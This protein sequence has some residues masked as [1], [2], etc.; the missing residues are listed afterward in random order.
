MREI[1]AIF[2][3]LSVMG[4]I[5]Y[6]LARRLHQGLFCFFPKWRFWPV[7]TAIYTTLILLVA[8]FI[9]GLT[10][11]PKE[12]KHILSLISSYCMGVMLYLLLF[13]VTA[14]LLLFVPKRM[15]LSFT[16]HRLFKGLVTV[17]V[18][19]LTTSTCV[20][21][22]INAQT[23][24][25]VS[26]DIPLSGKQDVSDMNIVLVS[27][28]HLGSIGSESRLNK[29]VDEIN[30][31]NP[32]LVCIAG[33]FFDTDF[34]AI[35]DPDAALTTLRKLNPTYGTY[36][37]LGNHDG[38][39]THNQMVDFLKKANIHLLNDAYTLIDNRLVL[40]GR[41]DSH[42]IGGY[43]TEKR[44]ELG[45]FFSRDNPTLPVI[46]MDHNP[47]NI[48]QYTT[49]ADLILCGHTHQGQ[50]FPANLI[51]ELMYTVDYG[52]YRKDSHSPHVV[53]TSGVGTWGMP[54]RVG[55]GC[56]IVSIRLRGK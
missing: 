24:R 49:E 52:Y 6:Y 37:C 11:F 43:G 9:Q 2:V 23:I 34:A 48:N 51:T 42:S 3:L 19:L 18:L 13:T 54:M 17:A 8:G 41:L 14:D 29:I 39:Q 26:Y 45:Q 32:D 53:V 46:V 15:K 36:A 25:H 21:G 4:G 38:G 5:G 35:Q 31:L 55:T 1:I 47:A 27:D 16:S 12:V 30:A 20:G 40:M 56:E 44:K 28:V 33:D 7:L 50:V 10:P 22:F